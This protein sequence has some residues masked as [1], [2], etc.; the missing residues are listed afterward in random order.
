MMSSAFLLYF[1][2]VFAFIA[3]SSYMRIAFILKSIDS[4]LENPPKRPNLYDKLRDYKDWCKDREKK[5]L[6]FY[7]L[8]IG[9]VGAILCWTPIP[10]VIFR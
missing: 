3:F 10:W 6:A 4:G 8:C 1:F 7:F 2:M 9:V 5:P